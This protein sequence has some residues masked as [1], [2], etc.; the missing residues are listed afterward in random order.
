M[1]TKVICLVACISLSGCSI[2]QIEDLRTLPHNSKFQV[3]GSLDCVYGKG[4]EQVSSYIGM[5]EPKFTW[6][7]SEGKQYA[8][9]RQP[10]TIVE[11]RTVGVNV[12]EVQRKQTPSAE[13]FGQGNDLLIYFKTNPCATIKSENSDHQPVK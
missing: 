8:W 9:F 7:I 4:V 3:T 10:L 5:S 13:I 2:P 12:T 6:F 11:L 1:K